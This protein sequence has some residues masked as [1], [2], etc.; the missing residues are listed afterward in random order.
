MIYQFFSRGIGLFRVLFII[1]DFFRLITL[2]I[3]LPVLAHWI[4]L[5]Y[6]LVLLALVIGLSM[7][8]YDYTKEIGPGMTI[9]LDD[10]NLI[11]I[12][13]EKKSINT[14]IF[15]IHDLIQFTAMTILIPLLLNWLGMSRTFLWIGV[16]L[17]IVI[18]VHDFMTE[19]GSGKVTIEDSK[20]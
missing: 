1:D 7:D 9:S 6:L 19:F 2:T 17:G 15:A 4:G 20:E 11:R 8:I 10:F 14:F 12:I 16:L 3:L 13:R 5:P 18:D